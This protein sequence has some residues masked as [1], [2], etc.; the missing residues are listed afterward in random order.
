MFK[1]REIECFEDQDKIT[2]TEPP[3]FTI[4]E[5]CYFVTI[6]KNDHDVKQA[7]K[8]RYEVFKKE[9]QAIGDRFDREGL[10]MDDYDTQ[11]H[12]LIVKH[13]ESGRVVGTYRLQSWE[14]ADM[15]IGFYANT[16]FDISGIPSPFLKQSIEIGR[17][18]IHKD[19][20]NGRVLY[21][22][23]KGLAA[24]LIGMGKTT[25]LGCCS[26][27]S[28]NHDE[29]LFL[30]NS[31]EE[32]KYVARG[33]KVSA[34]QDYKCFPSRNFDAPVAVPEIPML[35]QKYLDFGAKV[36]SDPAI[37]REFGSID[38]LVMLHFH[39]MDPQIYRFFT[40]DLLL[41]TG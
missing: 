3:Q 8:L 22:L 25:L 11:C 41:Q 32:K 2:E 5:A 24:S 14:M 12:H 38:Y 23:W 13:R 15:G 9:L 39:Q 10:E 1:S 31:L 33:L 20:R 28:R 7:L 19:H 27:F 29:G 30:M 6:A 35:F 21:M 16:Q 4:T 26:L 37:D 17:G 40:R 34:R 18:C 36:C